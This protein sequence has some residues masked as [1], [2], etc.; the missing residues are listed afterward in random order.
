MSRYG[1]ILL[2]TTEIIFRVYETTDHEWKLFHYHSSLI[3]S[4]T[5]LETNIIVE[6]IGNFFSTPYAQH[7]AEWKICSRNYS[8]KIIQELSRAIDMNI[9]DIS[10]HREQELICKG[11]FTEL[12]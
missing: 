1:I 4:T 7:V 11:M 5:Q 8:K 9:E 10:L 3:P 12:W 6:I 2:E